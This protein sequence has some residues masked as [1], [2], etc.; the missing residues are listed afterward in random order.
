MKDLSPRRRIGH[1]LLQHAPRPPLHFPGPRRRRRRRAV[2][3]II[4]FIRR[5]TLYKS[6]NRRVKGLE[7][8]DLCVNQSVSRVDGVEVT[9][10]TRRDILI[11]APVCTAWQPGMRA[12]HWRAT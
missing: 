6:A 9:I 1:R 5:N 8:V 12:T 10:E 11:Y 4:H 7:V 3:A 2:R